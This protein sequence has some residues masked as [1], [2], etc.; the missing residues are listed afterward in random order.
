[1]AINHLTIVALVARAFKALAPRTVKRRTRE[2]RRLR[3][4]WRLRGLDFD[5]AEIQQSLEQ[6]KKYVAVLEKACA[7]LLDNNERKRK[8]LN[9]RLKGLDVEELL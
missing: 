5:D 4:Q 9:R 2:L 1:M 3:L 7:D 8:S 6:E